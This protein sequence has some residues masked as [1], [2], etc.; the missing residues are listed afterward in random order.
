MKR[1]IFKIAM[2]AAVLFVYT[3]LSF[4][5]ENKI[6]AAGEAKASSAAAP[7]SKA[8]KEKSAKAKTRVKLVDINSAGK[9]ELKTLPGIKDAEADKI[10][11]GRPYLSKADLL[12]QKIVSPE[13][14]DGLKAGVI[15]KQNEA[16][17]AKLSKM[18]KQNR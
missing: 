7:V 6:G 13:T 15:A 12:T 9:D 18:Q 17:A 2:V 3:D 14:Y 16:T 8:A 5:A 11:A 1:N 4:A 10:V